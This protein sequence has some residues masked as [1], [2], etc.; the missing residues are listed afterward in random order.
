M[1]VN[2]PKKQIS[3]IVTNAGLTP[4]FEDNKYFLSVM[5][6][7][8]NKPNYQVWAAVM[9]LVQGIVPHRVA[10][11]SR[12][13]NNNREFI[14]D[15]SKQN[16]VAYKN[17]EDF[18]LLEDETNT[19]NKLNIVKKM[20]RKFNTKQKNM[21]LELFEPVSS[22]G[23]LSLNNN[24]EF[25]NWY[26]LFN[27]LSKLPADRQGKFISLSSAFDNAKDIL[28]AVEQAIKPTYAWNKDEA[29]EFIKKNAKDCSIIFDNNNVL[30]LKVPSFKSS[31]KLCGGGR[32]GW[33]LT[34]ENQYFNSYVTSYDNRTQYFLFNFN[35]PETDELAHIGFTVEDGV[36]ITNAHST[37]N[38]NMIGSGF[39][40]RGKA[41]NIFDALER[42][43]FKLGNL[44]T[45]NLKDKFEWNKESLKKFFDGKPVKILSEEGNKLVVSTGNAHC[46]ETICKCGFMKQLLNDTGNL[47]LIFDFDKDFTEE[48]SIVGFHLIEDDFKCSVVNRL[49]TNYG[50]ILCG[51]EAADF[52]KDTLQF[53]INSII[54]VKVNNK[55]LLI[56]K[57]IIEKKEEEAIKLIDDTPEINVNEEY[58][59]TYPI[60]GAIANTMFDLFKKITLHP[61][62]DATV[63]EGFGENVLHTLLFLASGS[64]LAKDGTTS[65]ILNKMINFAIDSGVYNLN[66]Q[67]I[68]LDTAL[69]IAC[70]QNSLAWVV[71]KL[72]NEKNVDISIVNDEGMNALEIAVKC[73]NKD[74][75]KSLI[76]R[77]DIVVTEKIKKM[78]ADNAISLLDD[79]IV[80]ISV[81]KDYVDSC[82]MLFDKIFTS[83]KATR[84]TW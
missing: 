76:K 65:E 60:F 36:G 53:D 29:M 57:Y 37:K 84:K 39:K 42:V 32:T 22:L 47:Y 13:I 67:D 20:I 74:A 71:E 27:G 25:K 18:S 72:V 34:R 38:M 41:I 62:F 21:L 55:S 51:T 50:R 75:V 69:T 14:K 31:H 83:S 8:N 3:Q 7:L 54:D 49:V 58:K 77:T 6:I 15:L 78:A 68:N 66:E 28:A 46:M 23:T 43:G 63:Q 82:D 35:K 33:C 56:H 40:Y 12:W 80:T 4:S 70:S 1:S 73:G 11:I 81:S 17:A 26:K 9:M 30:V 61:T 5:D 2:Y 64:I 16:I 24:G 10:K 45:E 52:C 48:N 59:N 44:F 79:D 19:I